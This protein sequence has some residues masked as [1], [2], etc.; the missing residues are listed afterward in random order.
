MAAK[1]HALDNYIRRCRRACKKAGVEFRYFIVTSDMD[2]K[3]FD[4]VRVHHHMVVNQEAAA[5]CC[6]KW[7]DG[8]TYA[9]PL[10]GECGDLTPLAEYMINQVRYF[11]NEKRYTPSRNLCKPKVTPV[12][13][14]KNPDAPLQVPKGCIYIH[15]SESYAGRPQ[16]LR[17]YRPPKMGMKNQR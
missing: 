13:K 10:Y 5:I 11:P 6:E 2:G 7:K 8:G 17:Y 9:D 12:R 1:K 16:R 4:P 14:C 3:S 15:R